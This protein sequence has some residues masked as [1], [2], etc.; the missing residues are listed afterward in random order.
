M[1]RFNLFSCFDINAN[2]DPDNAFTRSDA[3]TNSYTLIDGILISYELRDIVSDIRI[4]HQG[5]NLSDHCPVEVVI[6]VEVSQSYF[7]KPVLP[8]YV[9]WKKLTDMDKTCFE[10]AMRTNLACRN[11]PFHS[12]L[13]GDKC[14]FDD[15]HTI[16][17]ERN[18]AVL[19]IASTL[20]E[21]CS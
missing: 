9:N 1:E 21:C 11:E 2:F 14:C 19:Q 13:H 7:K 16:F 6:N 18:A 20:E 4:V 8:Q 17:A 3:K 15:S 12:I 5:D 10:E